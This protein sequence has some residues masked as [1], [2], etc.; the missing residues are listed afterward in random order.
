MTIKKIKRTLLIILFGALS[1]PIT[2][3]AQTSLF[4]GDFSATASIKSDYRFR[5]V[6]KTGNDF[7]VQGSVDYFSDSGFYTGVW[8]SNISDYRGADIE[9]NLYA[10]FNKEIDGLI[11]DAG[12]TAYVYPGGDNTNYIET[13]GSV[14]IDLGLLTSSFGVA[15]TFSNDNLGQDDIYLFTEARAV[16]PDTPFSVDLHLGYEDGAFGNNKWDWKI[17]GNFAV[18]RFELGIAYVDTNQAG[19]RSDSGVIFSLSAFF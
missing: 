3:H 13:Y 19:Q 15:Y 4:E 2:G 6:S 9:T 12:I 16:I 5:G 11:Y 14:G 18:D 17:G 1:V 7:A 10:G 8:A